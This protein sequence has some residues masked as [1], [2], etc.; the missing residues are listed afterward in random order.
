GIGLFLWY[1]AGGKPDQ[2]EPG[3]T[4]SHGSIPANRLLLACRAPIEQAQDVNSINREASLDIQH[5]GRSCR[6]AR[7]PGT[8]PSRQQPS[9]L[10]HPL[11]HPPRQRPLALPPRRARR[12]P[13]D[14]QRSPAVA[15]ARFPRRD[16]G[17]QRDD[18]AGGHGRGAEAEGEDRAGARAARCQVPPRRPCG[19]PSPPPAQLRFG[20]PLQRLLDLLHHPPGQ[21]HRV[22]GGEEH[23][24]SPRDA[25]AGPL[26]SGAQGKGDDR[27]AEEEG[28]VQ[29]RRRRGGEEGG[30]GGEEEEDGGEAVVRDPCRCRGGGRCFPAR[31]DGDRDKEADA[32]QPRGGF[33]GPRG[34]HA[35]CPAED[36]VPC[37]PR[38]GVDG[39]Q[40]AVHGVHDRAAVR[41]IRGTAGD[42]HVVLLPEFGAVG[43]RHGRVHLEI[44]PRDGP[45]GDH[46]HRAHHRG[47]ERPP[48]VPRE[49]VVHERLGV[50]QRAPQGLLRQPAA[51]RPELD[52]LHGGAAQRADPLDH[53]V[54]E[55]RFLVVQDHEVALAAAVPRPAGAVQRAG[56]AFLRGPVGAGQH[57]AGDGAAHHAHRRGKGVG[58]GDGGGPPAQPV[59]QL[60]GVRRRAEHQRDGPHAQPPHRGDP[61]Q[62]PV[63]LCQVLGEQ[64]HVPLGQIGRRPV[65]QRPQ[66]GVLRP[67]GL[68]VGAEHAPAEAGGQHRR[69]PQVEG[70]RA[71]GGGVAAVRVEDVDRGT[72]PILPWGSV[73]GGHRARA[74][75][76]RPA[77]S[78]GTQAQH[79]EHR[80]G[81]EEHAALPPKGRH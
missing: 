34:A 28:G 1:D 23:R 25:G 52:H 32:G 22:G 29:R 26:G 27:G 76:S 4:G 6:T 10:P 58:H 74:A 68:G 43:V 14:E 59:G 35:V 30:W 57:R 79:G 49:R 17:R 48:L 64:H 45:V 21:R 71:A 81:G 36:G 20:R 72:R 39:A 46:R 78:L 51:P 54:G 13:A 75:R 24:R 12:R 38:G 50:R 7:L 56:P 40:R 65:R 47:L 80:G 69:V 70:G 16:R 77:A 8:A 9:Q 67:V 5:P 63:L 55:Q 18:R 53:R 44:L 42:P 31:G 3:F 60:A 73:R 2:T 41:E 61:G 11:R 37:S 19:C 33:R 66:R 15:A 62:P